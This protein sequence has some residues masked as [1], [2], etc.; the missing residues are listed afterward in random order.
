MRHDTSGWIA[1]RTL[2][3]AAA[4]GWASAVAADGSVRLLV[5]KGERKLYVVR[6]GAVV[7]DY[8]IALG[9]QPVGAKERQGDGRTPEGVYTID[10]RTRTTPFHGWLNISYPGAEDRARAKA[11][12]VDPGARIAIH[13]LPEDWGP[14][15]PGRP[16]IDWTNGCIAMTNHDLD[17]LWESVA[18]GTV[19]EIRP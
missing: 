1:R 13:G 6:D 10:W 5:V 9:R 19:V 12:G 4:L 17:E 8:W 14:E 11:L 2:L 16:M 3:V 7:K 15:G 18:D